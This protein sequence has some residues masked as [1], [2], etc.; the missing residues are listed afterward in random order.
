MP[1]PT[2]CTTFH[3]LVIGKHTLLWRCW[4]G[5]RKGIWPVKNWVV[6]MLVWLCVWVKV[7][8]CIRPSWCHCHSQSRAPANPDWFYLPCFTFWC[9]LIQV[10]P[11]KIQEGHKMVV[12]V[13]VCVWILGPFNICGMAKG[14]TSNFVQR[15]AM[16]N[17]SLEMI[18]CPPSGHSHAHAAILNFG[19]DWSN[20][21][22]MLYTS[23]PY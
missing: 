12:C 13:C 18:N 23:R 4:F 16:W 19:N 1:I 9:Q 10:V 20:S 22:Q 2:F 21:R 11:D 14:E 3:I 7:Q 15:L 6:G 5:G 17:I 8:I